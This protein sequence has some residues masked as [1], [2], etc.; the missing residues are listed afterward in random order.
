M[1]VVTQEIKIQKEKKKGEKAEER[2]SR[3]AD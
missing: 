3:F 2:W 1:C